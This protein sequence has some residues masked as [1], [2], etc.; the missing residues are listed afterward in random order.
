M[1]EDMPAVSPGMRRCGD[2]SELDDQKKAE[3]KTNQIS[4]LKQA[5]SVQTTHDKIEETDV[6]A[7]QV[8]IVL[9][10]MTSMFL[11]MIIIIMQ[12]KNKVSSRN[13]RL[14]R[15]TPKRNDYLP[16]HGFTKININ[17]I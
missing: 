5:E 10:A 4:E 16:L 8:A 2:F 3:M 6:I 11:F 15:N 7:Y 9:L 17:Q 12:V 13:T 14:Y 1:G